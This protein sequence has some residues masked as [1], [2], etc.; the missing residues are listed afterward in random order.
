VPLLGSDG[1]PAVGWV[2]PA[3]DDLN[4]V[5]TEGAL[6]YERLNAL[7]RIRWA[8][9]GLVETDVEARL[10]H[11]Q[12]GLPDDTV[13]LGADTGFVG[14]GRAADVE[15]VADDPERIE[16]AVDAE[17]A[18]WLVVADALQNGWVAELDGEEVPLVDADHALVAV[19]VPAGQHDVVLR[20]T[21]EGRDTGITATIL[22][23]LILLAIA[24]GGVVV[25]SRRRAAPVR[26]RMDASMH[27]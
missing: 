5:H 1:V 15:V 4:L 13:V 17:G 25:R 6:V 19:E 20:Y 23:A 14:D 18:G 22:C 10:S 12:G 27:P 16:V 26:S 7:P 21:G 3:D 11:L 8:G 2:E 24:V 9:T